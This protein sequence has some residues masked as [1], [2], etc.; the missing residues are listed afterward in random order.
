[1]CLSPSKWNDALYQQQKN[2]FSLYRKKESR[3]RHLLWR[4][5]QPLDDFPTGLHAYAYDAAFCHPVFVDARFVN[6]VKNAFHVM[7]SKFPDSRFFL[8]KG[9][10]HL[11]CK[12]S[13]C[14][15]GGWHDELKV[16]LG[17]MKQTVL[18]APSYCEMVS[19]AAGA[20]HGDLNER[21]IPI[22]V[23]LRVSGDK[24]GPSLWLKR[25][26]DCLTPGW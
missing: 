4:L 2:W 21:L 10:F 23:A 20:G 13:E 11:T 26:L 9:D 7:E 19:S 12:D 25:L 14:N 18:D 24:L 1:V 15:H 16:P 22:A 8:Q 3:V 17:C 5:S 6:A